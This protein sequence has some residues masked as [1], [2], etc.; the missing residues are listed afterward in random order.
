[1]ETYVDSNGKTVTAEQAENEFRK[2]VIVEG[3][4]LEGEIYEQRLEAWMNTY[5]KKTPK[6]RRRTN[7]VIDTYVVSCVVFVLLGLF[8]LLTG[9]EFV[10]F[11][12][13]AISGLF[14]SLVP[15][16]IAFLLTRP[17]KSP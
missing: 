12:L 15:M 5:R 13:I 4:P 10:I 8:A 17:A 9:A 7:T 3:G 2:R 6:E 1:M 16:A 14:V 11:I